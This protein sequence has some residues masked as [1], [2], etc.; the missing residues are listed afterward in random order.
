MKLQNLK[1]LLILSRIKFVPLK[2]TNLLNQISAQ[3][4]YLKSKQYSL[5]RECSIY[6]IWRPPSQS[7]LTLY[8]ISSGLTH[9]VSEA[10]I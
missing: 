4:D 8:Q 3:S 10:S 7:E 9:L 2:R 1:D 5:F 6:V